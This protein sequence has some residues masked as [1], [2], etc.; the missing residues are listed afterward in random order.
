[1]IVCKTIAECRAAREKLGKLAFVPTMG[2]LHAGH[3]S[4]MKI[5]QRHAPRVAVSIF[6][7]PDAVRAERGFQAIPP[8]DRG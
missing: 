1:M 7:N 2:A 5:A 4:L 8:P 6:V 3:D